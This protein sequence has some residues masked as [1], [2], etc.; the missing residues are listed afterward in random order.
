MKSFKQFIVEDEIEELD[1][2]VFADPRALEIVQKTISGTQKIVSTVPTGQSTLALF[3]MI[4]SLGYVA[5]KASTSEQGQATIKSVWSKMKAIWEK[6]TFDEQKS[7]AKWFK[8]SPH[9]GA[10]TQLKK[11]LEKVGMKSKLD[12]EGRK[13]YRKMR[14]EAIKVK[15]EIRKSIGASVKSG[16]V[17]QKVRRA[18]E[19]LL[20]VS[21]VQI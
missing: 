1:E 12:P 20:Q 5:Y 19:D 17:S 11:E 18:I 9:F 10:F 21:G 3:L 2:A 4:A 14:E 6:L 16:D 8:N 7:A 13:K 15:R